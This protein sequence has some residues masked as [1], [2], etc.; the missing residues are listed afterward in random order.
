MHL[1]K[2]SS[3][4]GVTN[5]LSL[6]DLVPSLS[7]VDS[8]VTQLP[9]SRTCTLPSAVLGQGGRGGNGGGA[10]QLL[11]VQIYGLPVLSFVPHVTLTLLIPEADIVTASNCSSFW[12][13]RFQESKAMATSSNRRMP[14]IRAICF[15][16]LVN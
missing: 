7:H 1:Y 9:F 11:P 3:A 14:A 6:E 16:C 4:G 5:Q 13:C 10:A 15:R 2:V 8:R 12:A